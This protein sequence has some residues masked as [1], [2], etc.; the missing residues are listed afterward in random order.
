MRTGKPVA[1]RLNNT[2]LNTVHVMKNQYRMKV[3]TLVML[4]TMVSLSLTAAEY[5][6]VIGSFAEESNARSFAKRLSSTFKE[7]TYSFNEAR[8]L[9]YV[10][11]M[12]TSRKEEASN[13]SLYLRNEKGFKDAWVLAFP[14]TR[15]N[16]FARAVAENRR[17]ARYT[18]DAMPVFGE[19]RA[20]AS[21][22]TRDELA[23]YGAVPVENASTRNIS[24][25]VNGDF[26]FAR[27]ISNLQD[28]KEDHMLASSQRFTFIVET[29]DGKV[30]P[31]EVML[32]NFEKV[33]K[34]AS[35]HPGEEVAIRPAKKNQMVTFVCD[36]LG[37]SMETRMFN[38]D[39]LS[40][41]RDIEKNKNGVWEVRFKL[42]KLQV[43]EVSFMNKATF[44][45]DAAVLEPSSEVQMNNLLMM[46]QANPGYKIIIHTHCNP[47][48]RRNIRV[49]S[50][51]NYFDIESAEDKAGSDKQL[52]KK[53]AELVRN[54][55]VD[56]GI[57]K[58][59]N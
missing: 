5:Y 14:E 18:A 51:K 55:L 15:E 29:A 38:M 26:S 59:T 39:H 58:K 36:E 46:M 30:I 10:H 17:E 34:L 9:Y 24:W 53:R 31:S 3:L 6:V 8:N 1:A 37:Y 47:G 33:K 40:R 21:S 20:I 50:A 7:V 28:V 4:F 48:P 2:Q 12:K 43:N 57:E 44:Y 11:V 49:P 13:W 19:S 42:K 16:T 23:A 35:F 54:Y 52:T 22:S 45:K 32:V 56:H 27:G 25:T 41:G